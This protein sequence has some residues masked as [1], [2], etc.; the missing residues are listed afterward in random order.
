MVRRVVSDSSP[1]GES[2]AALVLLAFRIWPP[3][4]QSSASQC[5]TVS[6]LPGVTYA[7]PNC[8]LAGLVSALASAANW[9]QVQSGPGGWRPAAGEE[10][11]VV[12][13]RQVVDQRGNADDLAFDGRYVALADPE[14]DS[15]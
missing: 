4:S 3:A 5:Q 1:A 9:L 7:V 6:S 8:F 13:D 15:S 14:V 12:D 11:L 10:R 2:K